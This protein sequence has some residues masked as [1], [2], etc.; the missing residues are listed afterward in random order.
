MAVS[1]THNDDRSDFRIGVLVLV[2]V[3]V[4]DRFNSIWVCFIDPQAVFT[5]R[6]VLGIKDLFLFELNVANPE[7]LAVLWNPYS[8]DIT[9]TISNEIADVR[10]RPGLVDC[11][12]LIARQNLVSDGIG[13][14][15]VGIEVRGIWLIHEVCHILIVGPEPF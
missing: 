3:G 4:W 13:S 8:I 1:L 10:S 14:T 2:V 9:A 6:F 5:H 15:A 12:I 7:H 11:S